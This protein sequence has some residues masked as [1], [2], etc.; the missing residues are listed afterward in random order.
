MVSQYKKVFAFVGV[1]T[2]MLFVACS[3]SSSN[4]STTSVEITGSDHSCEFQPQEGGKAS[5]PASTDLRKFFFDKTIDVAKV[6]PLYQASGVATVNYLEAQGI[7]IRG[8]SRK[9]EQKCR[10]YLFLDSASG[11]E[12]GLWRG[13]ES[14]INDKKSSIAGVFFPAGNI[15]GGVKFDKPTIIV[16]FDTH[17]R[18][19]IHEYFHYLY[20][21]EAAKKPGYK[22]GHTL[23]SELA[24]LEVLVGYEDYLFNNTAFRS[25]KLSEGQTLENVAKFLAAMEQFLTQFTLEEVAIEATFLDDYRD[26]RYAWVVDHRESAIAYMEGSFEK[27]K[28]MQQKIAEFTTAVLE[29]IEDR[30]WTC[31]NSSQ[32]CPVTDLDRLKADRVNIASVTKNSKRLSSLI[33]E[34]ERVVDARAWR[35]RNSSSSYGIGLAP[36]DETR[37][38]PTT[39]D[40]TA[41]APAPCAQPHAREIEQLI[42]GR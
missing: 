10:R 16:G 8:V 41:V 20:D 27:A 31:T 42:L 7:Q 14:E 34:A 40:A 24:S 2:T 12:L 5:A 18:V 23:A 32:N 38:T 25:S 26:N 11:P 35:Y 9:N 15:T 13:L 28:A 3:P 19:L 29:K 37:K 33:Q 30:L 6:E 1:A 21:F 22:L 36:S 4:R 17:R 39:Q